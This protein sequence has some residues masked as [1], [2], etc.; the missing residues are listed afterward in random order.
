MGRI[1]SFLKI[2]GTYSGKNHIWVLALAALI[3]LAVKGTK[4]EWRIF[5]WPVLCALCVLNPL[6]VSLIPDSST[7]GDRF[8]RFFWVLPFYELV[9]YTAVLLA[10]KCRRKTGRAA[11]IVLTAAAVVLTGNMVFFGKDVP[12]Y[13]LPDNSQYTDD[14]FIALKEILHADGIERPVVLYDGHLMLTYRMYDPSVRSVFSREGFYRLTTMTQ[15]ELY[16]SDT[17]KAMQLIAGF[18]YYHDFSIPLESFEKAA[19]V[20]GTDYI[21]TAFNSPLNEIFSEAGFEISG[22]TSLYRVWKLPEAPAS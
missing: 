2:F 16:A 19:A 4:D 21:V 10:G 6:T 17:Q 14:D 12:S 18:Y 11:V 7:I 8:I 15:E 9:G 5:V 20:K 3:F 22:E 13:E 1:I